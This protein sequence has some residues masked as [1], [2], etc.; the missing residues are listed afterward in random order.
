M[1]SPEKKSFFPASRSLGLSVLGITLCLLNSTEYFP[2][3]IMPYLLS[4]TDNPFSAAFKGA[5]AANLTFLQTRFFD[6]LTVY[7]SSS[8]KLE[9]RD[10][11]AL[12]GIF[13]PSIL[14][15]AAG[16]YFRENQVA[17]QLILAFPWVLAGLNVDIALMKFFRKKTHKYK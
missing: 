15:I 7:E 14:G 9:L 12:I 11:V 10:L 8:H 13:T 5:L 16:L 3:Q 17:Q 6:I 1:C 4:P 2:N